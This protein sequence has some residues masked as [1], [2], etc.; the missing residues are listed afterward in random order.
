MDASFFQYAETPEWAH[1]TSGPTHRSEPEYTDVLRAG[2]AAV[3]QLLPGLARTA[4]GLS[5]PPGAIVEVEV[6]VRGRRGPL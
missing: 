1:G 3:S 6:A 2:M 5:L 4:G